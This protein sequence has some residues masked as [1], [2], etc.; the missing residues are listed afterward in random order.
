MTEKTLRDSV[1]SQLDQLDR[2]AANGEIEVLLP[3]ARTDMYRL[4]HGFRSLLNEH[5][6]DEDGRCKVCPGTLRGRRWP[7]SVWTIAHRHLLA[8]QTSAPLNKH[9][10][11]H[12]AAEHDEPDVQVRPTV[13]ISSSSDDPGEWVTEE[14][15][16][17]ELPV[18]PVPS[19]TPVAPPAGG[20]LETDHRRIYR[21]A[22]VDRPV[23][24]PPVRW[25]GPQD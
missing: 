21:A 12:G 22:V 9:R 16:M 18:P 4:A 11:Q 23:Q 20:H 14:F 15:V 2:A 13:I 24:W 25:P 5:Q 3:V 17:P 7:C 8:D 6:P 10:R 1:L 19:W